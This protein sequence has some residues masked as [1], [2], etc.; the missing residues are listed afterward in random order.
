MKSRL[1]R[2]A[3]TIVRIWT[4]AYTW[5]LPPALRESRRAEIESDLWESQRDPDRNRGLSPA[6]HVIIRLLLGVPD[7]FQWRMSHAS[8]G[9]RPIAIALAATVVLVAALWV[10]DLGRA[11]ILPVPPPAPMFT[12]ATPAVL[13]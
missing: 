4:R 3:A 1:L 6:L 12:S 10:F 7:D 13:R 11:R 2:V 8:I 9:S 5:R